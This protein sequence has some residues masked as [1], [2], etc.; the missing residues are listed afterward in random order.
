LLAGRGVAT[1][2]L[3]LNARAIRRLGWGLLAANLVFT[4]GTALFIQEWNHRDWHGPVGRWLI[5]YVLVQ[6]HLATENVV[7]AWYSSMLLLSVA[8][9]ALLSYATEKGGLSPFSLGWLV[10]AAAFTALSLDE[11]GS[12]HERIGMVRHGGG[13]PT[14]WVY[15]LIVPIGAVALFMTAFA[16]FHLRRVRAAAGLFVLGT[17][18]F[19]SDPVFELAEM[20]L[21]RAGAGND[22]A[23]HNA[24][25]VIEEGIV[26]LGGALCFLLGVLVYTR[27][28]AG[29]GP[30][31]FAIDRWRAWLSI[32]FAGLAM[33]AGVPAAHWFVAQL[34]PGDTGIPDNWFP[35]A[36]WFAVALVA[37]MTRRRRGR[38]LAAIALVLSACCGAALYG[39]LGWFVRIGYPGEALDAFLT[40]VASFIVLAMT[41]ST[42]TEH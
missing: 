17:A 1:L 31:E 27:R 39:Y 2:Q 40:A 4:A 32:A 34:P 22:L 26:E 12:L 18:L 35:A 28:V 21:L 6:F 3:D 37:L 29:E 13:G 16:W 24:L 8:F 30:H 33:T 11:L 36:A 5:Q 19:L 7:A 23:V 20:A 15:V 42:R 38:P 25:L 41:V 9:A 10:I 14:G